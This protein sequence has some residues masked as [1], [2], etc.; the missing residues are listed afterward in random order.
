MTD[1]HAINSSLKAKHAARL[2]A[3]QGV[4]ARMIHAGGTLDAMLAW[5]MEEVGDDAP[6]PIAPEKKL[7]QGVTVGVEENREA[8]ESHLTRIL[9]D[10]WTGKRMGLLMRALLLCAIY[11]ALYHPKLETAI[12]VDQYVGVADAFLD[13]ADIGFVNGVLGEI[14]Q[15]VR[16]DA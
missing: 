15:D 6:L 13:D 7:L 14:L 9:S 3:V 16:G 11:E 2:A 10:R 1:S 4:Y 8:L 5:Q 12:L